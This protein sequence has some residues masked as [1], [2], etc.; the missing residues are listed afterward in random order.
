MNTTLSIVLADT[1]LQLKAGDPDIPIVGISSDS[2]A[3][4]PGFLFVATIGL[5]VDG[6]DY[7]DKA[8]ELGAVAVLAKAPQKGEDSRAT[9]GTG[10][11]HQRPN[12]AWIEAPDTN[13]VLGKVAASFYE[14]PSQELE[15][16]GITGTNGK[17]TVATLCYDLFTKLGY[18]C[19]LIGT[20]EVR[21]GDRV[22]PA[23]HTTPD[24]VAVQRRLREMA[25]AG[26]GYVFMEV[27]SHA[28][29][30]GRVNGCH[31]AGGV[32]TNISHD[33]LDYHGDM[34]SYINAKKLLFD[35]L[36]KTAFALVNLDDKRG[37]VMLQNC[38]AEHHTYALRQLADYKGRILDD[39]LRGLH[40]LVNEIEVHTRLA[41]SFN[42]Y[43]FLAAFGVAVELEQDESDALLALSSLRG[44]A[45]RLE[46]VEVP[47]QKLTGLVDYAHTP[48]A[49]KNV[50]ETLQPIRRQGH[51]LFTVF[52][53]GG[54]RDRSKRPL[55]GEIAAKM[56]DYVII[57]DD[58]PRTEDAA[59]IRGAIELGISQN[60][61][62]RVLQ[63]P[64]RRQAIRTAVR[65]A[66][67][68]DVILVAGK[69]HETYQ[70]INGVRSDFDDRAVLHEYLSP[71]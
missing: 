3:I 11:T 56:S 40:L 57:T 16:V 22:E 19:G 32:F 31:F 59:T 55:M 14:H 30:Q 62:D 9:R 1:G 18:R 67:D 58:N 45:G 2:R 42:A 15:V 69:G 20:V 13:A 46:V 49:L 21:I 43:N 28:L 64:D 39:S 6:H 68:E 24:A 70:E 54:D 5:T 52:G 12:V 29:V 35:G 63:I 48:D 10:H 61:R 53:C 25:D 51:Q 60:L 7:I 34:K 37:N 36:P 33:H 47:A 4:K 44:A 65:M 41:G 17:T 66:R 23:T 38:K 50:L 8:I 71:S 26:C 27:S